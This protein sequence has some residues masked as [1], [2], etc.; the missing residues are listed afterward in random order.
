MAQNPYTQLFTVLQQKYHDR[1]VSLADLE[2]DLQGSLQ[3]T[4]P[5][6]QQLDPLAKT[7]LATQIY[8]SLQTPPPPRVPRAQQ[9]TP[10]SVASSSVPSAVDP[11]SSVASSVNP[12]S[13]DPSLVD[14]SSSK[15]IASPL[16]QGSPGRSRP[17]LFA[18]L[19][20]R[21]CRC[22]QPLEPLLDW[23]DRWSTAALYS[24]GK[25]LQ[26]SL[27]S[28]AQVWPVFLG[29][30]LKSVVFTLLA[31]VLGSNT[32]LL[33]LLCC[34]F[35][36]AGFPNPLG[37]SL[38]GA[39]LLKDVV[40]CGWMDNRLAVLNQQVVAKFQNLDMRRQGSHVKK[41][42]VEKVEAEFEQLRA[43]RDRFRERTEALRQRVGKVETAPSPLKSGLEFL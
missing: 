7:Q 40:R 14:S 5:I 10:P 6:L 20:L 38:Q 37:Q 25:V 39:G 32:V 34:L 13:V 1:A 15:P 43:D 2:A 3:E 4:Y 33:L 28:Y 36:Q 24:G 35:P 29:F 11:S 16:A 23:I 30:P 9:P 31:L 12:S 18:P 41:R 42:W 22:P 8:N 27:G 26:V 21:Y 19:L 17:R